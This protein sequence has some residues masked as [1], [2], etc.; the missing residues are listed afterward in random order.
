MSNDYD[1]PSNLP[2][3]EEELTGTPYKVFPDK[4][5]KPGMSTRWDGG[6][7]IAG[8]ETTSYY[9]HGPGD[10]RRKPGR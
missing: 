9:R 4:K 8:G 5:W 2:E 10:W 6:S 1:F 3:G 7:F